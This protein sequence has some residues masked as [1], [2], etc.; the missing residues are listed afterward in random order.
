M[1]WYSHE[2][3]KAHQLA[4]E[5][6]K[7]GVGRYYK[8]VIRL[9]NQYNR[10][11]A[12]IG[13]LDINDLISAGHVGLLQA[14][15]KLDWELITAADEPDAH[16]WSYLKKR[17][18]WSIRREIDKYSQHIATPINKIEKQ[19][20]EASYEDQIFVDLFPQFFDTAFPDLI[21][22]MVPWKEIQLGEIMDDILLT[23]IKDYKH[24]QILRFAYGLD[25]NQLSIKDIANKFDMSEIGVKKVKA[26]SIEKLR[27]EDV[28]KII[29]NFYEN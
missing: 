16:L 8:W 14:W 25:C 13:V 5:N 19:R 28:E 6:Y 22:E 20:N 3:Y 17:I 29:E 27:N 26:R 24:I 1:K 9:A 2:T 15:N 10:E 21:E 12:S 4:V 7:K 18:K 23:Y 11:Y